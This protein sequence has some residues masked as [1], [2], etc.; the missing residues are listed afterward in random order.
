M[1]K[2]IVVLIS[3]FIFLGSFIAD[4]VP[5]NEEVNEE[6]KTA[7]AEY[8]SGSKSAILMEVSTKTILYE[9]N[10]HE[11]LAPASM[12]K[13]MTMLL[14]M[15]AIES[16]KIKLSDKVL[17]SKNAA[18]MGGT[19]IFVEANTEV[20][21]EDLLKGI[22]IASANDAAVALAEKIGGTEDNFID[23]MNKRAKE[24]GA[25]DTNF[26]NPHGLDEVNHYT[27]AYDLA[28][29]AT[30][31][32]KHKDILK[33]TSTYEEYIN[34]SGENHWLVN[35]NSLVRFYQGM[36]GLKT[37]YTDQAKY[38]LTSTMKKNNM[39]LVGVVMGSDTKEARNTDTINMMEYGFGMY[40]TKTIIKSNK[41]L[42][43]IYINNSRNRDV[44]YY[45]ENDVN[46]LIDVN[47]K[48]VDYKTEKEL[49]N[50]VKSPLKKGDVVGELILTYN[51]KEYKYNLVVKENIKKAGF[52]RMLYNNFKDLISGKVGLI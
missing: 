39:R 37:G 3:F 27:T 5:V 4:G 38:C 15:E 23:M 46:I 33:I 49:Y 14:A 42:G 10:A 6:N 2:I 21:V 48:D 31:L 40:N 25:V 7:N 28:L 30:E 50:N 44:S 34:V 35:T 18:G 22:G 1:K 29:V 41:K 26:K 52:I 45:A 13:I 43:T 9:K 36:D 20:K 32:V 24:L 51:K 47:T 8:A 11:K 16:G 12:T 19:Q 17:I